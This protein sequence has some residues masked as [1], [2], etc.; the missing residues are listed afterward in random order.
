MRILMIDNY[1][2][3][4][5]NLVQRLGEID[6]AV[7]LRVVR[8]DQVTLAEIEAAGGIALGIEADVRDHEAV[9]AMVA[10]SW[11]RGVGSMSCREFR[12]RS[13]SAPIKRRSFVVSQRFATCLT[14]G[15]FTHR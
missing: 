4:T 1:D 10:G 3:F 12:R 5:Y 14:T 15:A 6:P 7:E 9:E 8:N 13:W 2:S 11:R